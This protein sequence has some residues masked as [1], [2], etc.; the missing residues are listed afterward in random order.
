MIEKQ[1]YVDFRNNV[2]TYCRAFDNDT[3]DI[4]TVLNLIGDELLK[5]QALEKSDKEKAI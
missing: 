5:I 1:I 2:D 3:I 4:V